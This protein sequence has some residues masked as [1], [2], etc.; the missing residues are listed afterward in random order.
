MLVGLPFRAIVF[1]LDGTLI[2]SAGDLTSA[3]NCVLTESGR[4]P[5]TLPQVKRM[6]G[7]GSAKLVERGFAASGVPISAADLPVRLAR[8]LEVYEA[9]ANDLTRPYDGVT[10]TLARLAARGLKLGVC[11]NKPGRATRL[12]LEALDLARYFTAIAG[13]DAFSVRKPDPGHVLGLLDRL[14]I[15]PANAAMV[16]DNEHDAA[17]AR[18][19]GLPIIL[20]SYGYARASLSDIAPDAVIDR[21]AD[22]PAALERI[23]DRMGRNVVV[24]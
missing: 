18:A 8:F 12:V 1:D 3:L 21:F 2:D 13:G 5:V 4:A 6:V 17:A 14:G 19:A 11:T 22:L 7:D 16:G 10:D 24:P 20:V 9:G 23:G 15:S